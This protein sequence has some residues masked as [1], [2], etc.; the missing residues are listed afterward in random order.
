M[1][2]KIEFEGDTFEDSTLLKMILFSNK[3][4]CSIYDARDKIRSRLKY[5]E[6]VTDIE[7]QTLEAIREDLY[8]PELED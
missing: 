4:Y 1:K 6:N 3:I 2:F 7:E 8:I 5:G